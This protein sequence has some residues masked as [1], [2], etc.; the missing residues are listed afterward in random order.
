MKKYLKE[1]LK[2]ALRSNTIVRPWK[3]EIEHMYGMSADELHARNE[4][5][6]LHLFQ[7]AITH[8]PFY[9]QLYRENG[10]SMGDIQ[11]LEDITKLP[12]ITKEMIRQKPELL[13]CVSRKQ[14]V[15]NH[16]SGTTGTPL[17]VYESWPSIWIEQAH[18]LCHR[19]RCGFNHGKDVIA[20]LRGHLGHKD[21]T[22]YVGLSKTLYLSSFNLNPS[23]I[24][25]YIE[26]LKKFCPKAIEGYPSSLYELCRLIAA[27]GA[28][29]RIPIA[30]TSSEMLCDTSR[31]FIER[32][33]NCELFDHYG[34]TERTI[35][36]CEAPDH[37]G[38]YEAPG[39]SINEYKK[40]HVI[41]TSLINKAFPLIRYRMDD[42][43]TIYNI[44]RQKA[45][46]VVVKSIEGR[47][48][49][50]IVGKDNTR[51]N[52]AALTY[53]AKAVEGIDYLQ[54][55]Q[56]ELGKV[57]ILVV[58]SRTFN[59]NDHRTLG[60]AISAKIGKNN[61]DITVR[62]V[63]KKELNFSPSGKLSLIENKTI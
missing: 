19:K 9:Q 6:F 62:Q 31:Q 12:V 48:M 14:L 45:T 11:C 56:E 58:M 29:V 43:M 44:T 37:S 15:T 40:D 17:T 41:T 60:E 28:T 61:M 47:A 20:S 30:F 39:Y 3:T 63:K 32:T 26:A 25:N 21:Q 38:Y 16:T 59:Q 18:F 1:S 49:S 46:D 52:A 27:S 13:L 24:H 55:V 42:M 22:L 50:Y 53:V 33:L 7:K 10:I 54:F 36:L 2:Y 8:S 23:T 34:N 4:R 35:R 51:Y 57:T 5:C